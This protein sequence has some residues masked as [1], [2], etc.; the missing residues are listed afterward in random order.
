MDI[1]L[2]VIFGILFLYVAVLT[3]MVLMKK[4]IP[5]IM[6]TVGKYGIALLAIATTI[7]YIIR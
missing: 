2:Q 4:G 1:F 5:Q 7:Y 3:V 6:F